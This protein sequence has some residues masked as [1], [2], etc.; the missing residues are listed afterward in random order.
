MKLESQKTLSNNKE[1]ESNKKN[2]SFI[3]INKP[4]NKL[5]YSKCKNIYLNII[6]I[7]IK[8]LKNIIQI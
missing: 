4:L 8:W 5:F 6:F 1:N 2:I 7:F 3:E